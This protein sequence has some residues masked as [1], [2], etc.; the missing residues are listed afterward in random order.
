MPDNQN[1][2]IDE[3]DSAILKILASDPRAPYT[4]IA[5]EVKE[6]GYE[7]SGEG[8]RY[9][10]QRLMD[11]TTTFFFIDL[12]QVSGEIVRIAV[13]TADHEGAKDRTFQAISEMQFWHVTRGVGTYDI[14][15]VG[16][17][18]TMRGVDELLSAIRQLDTVESVEH[19]LAAERASSIETY[20]NA[21]RDE[22][23][24]TTDEPDTDETSADGDTQ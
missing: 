6:A 23:G 24:S 18:S 8:V 4:D 14:Y 5:Q 22:N 20:A 13:T 3:I 17:A 7:L 21:F 15:A 2:N 9:R 11:V 16:I 10:V 12:E 19:V 1:V